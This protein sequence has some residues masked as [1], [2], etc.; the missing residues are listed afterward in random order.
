M[1]R[2]LGKKSPVKSHRSSYPIVDQKLKSI[3][4]FDQKFQLSAKFDQKF[5]SIEKFDQKFQSTEKF[6]RKLHRLKTKTLH[7]MIKYLI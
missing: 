6:D 4:K 7:R 1:A 3:E 2:C 5:Q